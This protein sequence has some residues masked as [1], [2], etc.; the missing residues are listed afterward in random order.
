M[1]FTI[2][3]KCGADEAQSVADNALFEIGQKDFS[4]DT[5][6]TGITTD[7]RK[8]AAVLSNSIGVERSHEFT[9]ELAKLDKLFDDRAICFK[10]F[11]DANTHASDETIAQNA[12]KIWKKIVAYDLNF[13]KLGYEKE[14]AR[15]SSMI[16]EFEKPEMQAII[17]SLVGVATPLGEMKVAAI[18]LLDLYRKNQGVLAT[19]EEIIPSSVQSK[20]VLEIMNDKLLPYLSAMA[21]AK[22]AEFGVPFAKIAQ[23]IATINTKI[24]SRR[25]KTT[26]PEEA[27]SEVE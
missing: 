19:K 8:E 12:E 22:P 24:R 18:D 7:L 27:T 4:T 13:Y 17:A 2:L 3:S 15:A 14:L 25:S 11:V 21:N 26:T 23:Y 16:E 5:Y 6:L 10:S 9:A 20:V 1:D